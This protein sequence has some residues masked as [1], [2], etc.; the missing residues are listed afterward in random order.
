MEHG[1]VPVD[2]LPDRAG[3]DGPGL[4]ARAGRRIEHGA[5]MDA[6]ARPTAGPTAT[7]LLV[8]DDE[9]IRRAVH[10]MLRGFGYAVLE[11]EHGVRAREVLEGVFAAGAAAATAAAGVAT[12]GSVG[13]DLVLTDVWM[14]RL[15]GCAL[16]AWLAVV[17]PGL[18]VILMTGD[19]ETLADG[20]P[21]A[22]RHVLRKPFTPAE[23]AGAVRAGLAPPRPRGA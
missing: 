10:R 6:A 22:P 20:A 2:G 19:P 1:G 23:L 9:A 21:D 11:A 18:P 13:V 4:T 7:V 8:E 17:R 3:L 14:P 12:G 16:A 15:N 5:R